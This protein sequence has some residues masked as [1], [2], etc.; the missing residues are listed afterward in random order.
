MTKDYP[1]EQW[2]IVQ[3]HF[4]YTNEGRIEVSSFG[5]LRSFNKISNGNILNGSMI[6]GYKILRLK[7]YRPREEKLQKKLDAE[8]QKVFKLAKKLKALQDNNEPKKLI[9]ETA[10]LLADLKATLSQQFKDDLKERT[11]NY[12]SLVHRLVADYFLKKPTTKQ[13]I[14]AH[15]D[16]NKLNNRAHNLKW[17]TPEENYEH[18]QSSPY[19]IKE[20]QERRLKPKE[21][22]RATKLTVTKVM[23]MK[24]L[25]NQGKPMKALVK[26]FKVTETQI[27]RIRRGENWAD[28][29]AAK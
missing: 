24:K 6:N 4:E 22:S 9:A 14:V 18:Q 13:T 7:L 12:H 17:M 23:L 19:V 27:I 1:G 10:L 21:N 20:R 15:L 5:R 26:L 29:E 8:Q 16:H 28:I 25:L 11:I 3:F 2:K